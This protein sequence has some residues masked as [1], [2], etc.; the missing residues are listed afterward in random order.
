MDWIEAIGFLA[1]GLVFTTFCMKTM[2]PL[3]Y[4]A[5][6]SNVTFITY[7]ILG[8]VY[9][10]LVLHCCLLPL[11]IYRL[12]EIKR[13]VRD[14]R[15][16]AQGDLNVDWMLPFMKRRPF[17]SGEVLFRKGDKAHEMFYLAHGKVQLVDYG[18]D[19]EPGALIGEMGLFAPDQT[20][21]TTVTCATDGELLAI[22][23]EK[24]MELFYQN[25]EFGFALIRLVIARLIN[26]LREREAAVH[27][28]PAP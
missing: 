23:D 18:V 3:R 24:V 7:G 19:L 5:V 28:A 25:R 12:R 8:E 15:E 9:P 13:L 4:V 17:R 20:R 21:M 22:S 26:N 6:C 10:L 1:A 2:L 27:Q 16:A 11:N 14:V